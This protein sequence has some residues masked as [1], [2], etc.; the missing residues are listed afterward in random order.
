VL[1]LVAFRSL[2]AILIHANVK[3]PLGPLALFVGSPQLHH[4]HHAK[5]RDVGHSG[6]EGRGVN[7]G[8]L[9]PWLDVLFGTHFSPPRPPPCVGLS[10]PYPRGYVALMLAPF[11]RSP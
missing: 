1:G 8:N 5:G 4:W 9:A 11:R 7:F 2:W 10:E 6:P 3:L